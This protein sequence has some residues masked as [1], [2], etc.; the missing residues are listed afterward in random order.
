MAPEPARPPHL[1]IAALFTIGKFINKFNSFVSAQLM[2]SNLEL[3]WNTTAP[4]NRSSSGFNDLGSG[5]IQCLQHQPNYQPFGTDTPQNGVSIG[6]PTRI[7][8]VS[9]QAFQGGH[10]PMKL[11]LTSTMYGRPAT[12]PNAQQGPLPLTPLKPTLQPR[13][14]GTTSQGGLSM[15]DIDDLLR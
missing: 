6:A 12:S 5:F 8:N 13:E 3:T 9:Q 1:A 15:S 11:P 4:N 14:A 10:G 2:S 7:P